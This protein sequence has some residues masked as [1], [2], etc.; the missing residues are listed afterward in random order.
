MLTQ[1]LRDEQVHFAFHIGDAAELV[2]AG[3][4]PA[5]EDL[6]IDLHAA[7]TVVCSIILNLDEVL[8]RP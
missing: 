1:R 6:Y 3:A 5:E 8:C 7:M 2:S 4:A